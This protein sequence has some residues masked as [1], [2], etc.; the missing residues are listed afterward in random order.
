MPQVGIGST[1]RANE[2]RSEQRS[3]DPK[4][5]ESKDKRLIEAVCER[6][7]SLRAYEP[8][9][10][11]KGSAGV[12]NIGINEFKDHFKSHWPTTRAKLLIEKYIPQ[13]VRLV[14]IPKP[15]CGTRTLGILTLMDRLIQQVLHQKMSLIF[16]VEFSG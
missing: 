16:E 6:G 13:P 9:K 10:K 11:N 4:A 8:V 15:Y 14:N 3:D 7:N 5:D 12:N 2:S 1:L